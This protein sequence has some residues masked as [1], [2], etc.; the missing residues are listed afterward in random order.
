[1]AAGYVAAQGNLRTDSN[2]RVYDQDR[3][4]QFAY[5]ESPKLYLAFILRPEAQVS[6]D[7]D[8]LKSYTP[9]GSDYRG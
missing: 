7:P 2:S 8:A 5:A 1:M 3:G 6:G 9:Q 4:T